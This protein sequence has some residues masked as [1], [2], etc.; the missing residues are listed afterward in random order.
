MPFIL[1]LV[2]LTGCH[3]T[4]ANVCE[5]LVECDGLPTQ[6]MPNEECAEACVDQEELYDRWAD[7]QKQDA[8]TAQ[9]DCLR[10]ST[11]EDIAQGVCYDEYIWSW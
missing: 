1:V 5:K 2:S 6:R 4:C 10:D 11:C 3:A 8:L 9:L 7:V